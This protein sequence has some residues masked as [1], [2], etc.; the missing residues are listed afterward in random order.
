MSNWSLHHE[1]DRL[2]TDSFRDSSWCVALEM[3][4]SSHMAAIWCEAI[5]SSGAIK[6]TMGSAENMGVV[7]VQARPVIEMFRRIRA[8][9]T[10]TSPQTP[11]ALGMWNLHVAIAGRTGHP[12]AVLPRHKYFLRHASSL[13]LCACGGIRAFR[14]ICVSPDTCAFQSICTPQVK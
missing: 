9:A 4:R 1:D 6:G 5:F 12:T 13:I 2:H 11:S 14:C 7:H 3:S 8:L 10:R